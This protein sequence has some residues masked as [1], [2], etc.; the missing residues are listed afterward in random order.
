M[1][2][3][4]GGTPDEQLRRLARFV[5]KKPR[6]SIGLT[7]HT[8]NGE[9]IHGVLVSPQLYL[10]TV[11]IS[12]SGGW[13]TSI[14][15]V[16]AE[17]IAEAATTSD[18]YDYLHLVYITPSQ[19]VQVFRDSLRIPVAEVVAW[20]F[21]LLATEQLNKQ[22]LEDLAKAVAESNDADISATLY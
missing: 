18:A 21:N 4:S 2:S 6:I 9:I 20:T 5:H 15:P 12:A 11:Q 13:S 10:H 22:M 14:G 16:L 3:N 1:N 19:T 8:R 7:V 17:L